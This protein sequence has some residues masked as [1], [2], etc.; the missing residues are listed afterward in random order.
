VTAGLSRVGG[1]IGCISS[2]SLFKS[3]GQCMLPFRP[4]SGIPN[5]IAIRL[6][7]SKTETALLPLLDAG[8]V[9]DL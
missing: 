4:A 8:I 2:V 1:C 3:T 5:G 6:P 9:V 7:L